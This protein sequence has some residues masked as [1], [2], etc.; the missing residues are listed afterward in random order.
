MNLVISVLLGALF[1]YIIYLIMLAV[2]F[3]SPFATV[4]ALIAFLLVVFGGY[5]NWSWRFP[6]RP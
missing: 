1:A 3:L 2:P 6:T 4:G 5:S